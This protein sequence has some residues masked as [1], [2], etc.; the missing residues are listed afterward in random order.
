[1]KHLKLFETF[2]SN[3]YY[4]KISKSAAITAIEFGSEKDA[5][6]KLEKRAIDLSSKFP[7]ASI[8]VFVKANNDQPEVEKHYGNNIKKLPEMMRKM[9]FDHEDFNKA[10]I[11]GE[12]KV[13]ETKAFAI[14]DIILPINDETFTQ[15]LSKEQG[16]YMQKNRTLSPFLKLK[17]LITHHHESYYNAMIKSELD[18]L[19]TQPAKI[20]SRK[21]EFITRRNT[22][23]DF[24]KCDSI[25][26]ISVLISD[27][28]S[29]NVKYCQDLLH[30][31]GDDLAI[32]FDTLEDFS[33]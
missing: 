23:F 27:I 5:F 26:S 19:A 3:E 29:D 22:R 15:L 30:Q 6:K 1:M 10:K 25:R 12:F 21:K 2:T 16:I 8:E 7:D 14:I 32:V 20:F 24:F 4:E 13:L 18:I 9:E 33:S 28:L 17:V 31:D 11:F